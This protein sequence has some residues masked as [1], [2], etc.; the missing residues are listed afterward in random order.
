MLREGEKEMRKKEKKE[1]KKTKI[2]F[3]TQ[4]IREG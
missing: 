1:G 3:L 4:L 2:K